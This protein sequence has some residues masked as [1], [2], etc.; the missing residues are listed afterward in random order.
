MYCQAQNPFNNIIFNDDMLKIFLHNP[1]KIKD[2]HSHP[3]YFMLQLR[4]L[5]VCKK[6]VSFLKQE[7]IFSLLVCY[8]ESP[9]ESIG[10]G[11]ELM[12]FGRLLNAKSIYKNLGVFFCLLF[13]YQLQLEFILK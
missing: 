12:C 9:E 13:V 1:G 6:N 8:A 10:R 4:I 5:Q 11:L 3:F 7:I 2:A